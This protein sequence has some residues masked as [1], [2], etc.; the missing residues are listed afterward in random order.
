MP[1]TRSTAPPND[2]AQK[3]DVSLPGNKQTP[4]LVRKICSTAKSGMYARSGDWWHLGGNDRP[5]PLA[6]SLGTEGCSSSS[7]T[8]KGAD[9]LTRCIGGAEAE[10]G[11]SSCQESKAHYKNPDSE[12]SLAIF[13]SSRSLG[14]TS[15]LLSYIS[16]TSP[17][18]L[19]WSR[20]H[21]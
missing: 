2:E 12:S 9:P 15:K 13:S 14:S 10:S 1:Q 17:A 11:I 4:K 19:I 20:I 6:S 7:R 3:F 18:A 16:C 21:S 5:I 8:S